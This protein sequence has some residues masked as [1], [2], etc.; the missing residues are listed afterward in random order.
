MGKVAVTTEGRTLFGA[1]AVEWQR[2]QQ[3]I[4]TGPVEPRQRKEQ[5]VEQVR[6]SHEPVDHTQRGM[7]SVLVA[8][9]LGAHHVVA[10]V[11]ATLLAQGR[12]DGLEAA[13]EPDIVYGAAAHA[14]SGCTR[15]HPLRDGV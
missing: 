15:S 9:V 10:D 12:I 1:R 8:P 14:R 2:V 5:S 7:R 4:V 13:V 11:A 6:R 3:H